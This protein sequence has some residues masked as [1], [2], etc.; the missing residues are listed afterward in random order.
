MFLG[1][2]MDEGNKK[3]QNNLREESRL[4]KNMSK[5][6]FELIFLL[7]MKNRPM[8]AQEIATKIRDETNWIISVT[9]PYPVIRRLKSFGYIKQSHTEFSPN[10]VLRVYY[11]ITEKG[12]Q[13]LKSL[14]LEY[15]N[16]KEGIECLLS[17]KLD[18]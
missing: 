9:Q 17:N 18:Q 12:L 14:I 10:N 11:S 3:I 5:A 6:V 4:S 1:G 7:K 13:Y 8:Y 2:T 15:E 16:F